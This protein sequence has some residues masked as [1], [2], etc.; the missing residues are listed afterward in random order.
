MNI[1]L[2][3]IYIVVPL[4]LN[5]FI[6]TTKRCHINTA[7]KSKFSSKKVSDGMAIPTPLLSG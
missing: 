3:D 7:N 6:P 1:H 4:L 5:N 2:I